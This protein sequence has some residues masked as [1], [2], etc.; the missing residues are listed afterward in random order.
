M[1][2][3]NFEREKNYFISY[4]NIYR[5]C[6]RMLDELVPNPFKVSNTPALLGWNMTMS[7]EFILGQMESSYG[8]PSA[9]MLFSNDTLFK[10]A[11]AASDTPKALFYCMEQCQEIM[12]LGNLAYAPE[13]VIANAIRVLMA[14]KMFLTRE[15]ETWDATANK[16]YP[17]YSANFSLEIRSMSPSFFY[18]QIQ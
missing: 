15:F 3:A 6:F 4:K 16:T 17:A 9:A 2:D 13:Q 8:K 1:I 14:S 7:I 12:T 5:A 18:C 11:I 10:S